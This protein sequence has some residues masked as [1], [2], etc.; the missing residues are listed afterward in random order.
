MI[1]NPGSKTQRTTINAN[2]PNSRI[3]GICKEM[4]GDIVGSCS[5]YTKVM[6][7][8]VIKITN[9]AISGR[10]MEAYTKKEMSPCLIPTNP[11]T[12]Q[13]QYPAINPNNKL[14]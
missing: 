1:L 11:K 14:L 4:P 2:N 7:E 6:V 8:I 5:S 3:S 9:N 13:K 12:Y 10:L